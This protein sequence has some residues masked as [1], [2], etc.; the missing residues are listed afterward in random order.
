M[1]GTV[2][3]LI[4][5]LNGAPYGLD[6]E[7][8]DML[9]DL[10]VVLGRSDLTLRKQVEVDPDELIESLK[11]VHSKHPTSQALA[12]ALS[13]K[14]GVEL[15]WSV[16]AEAGGLFDPT[17]KSK[18]FRPRDSIIMV[19]VERGILPD[20]ALL[21]VGSVKVATRRGKASKA[22]V[23]VDTNL[24]PKSL[25]DE[26]RMAW[27]RRVIAADKAFRAAHPPGSY[28]VP[29]WEPSESGMGMIYPDPLSEFL[30]T[31]EFSRDAKRKK[32]GQN[33]IYITP[34]MFAKYTDE[35]EPDSFMWRSP[36]L[37]QKFERYFLSLWCVPNRCNKCGDLLDGLTTEVK[38][39]LRGK[40]FLPETPSAEMP[41]G[42]RPFMGKHM[43]NRCVCLTKR[44]VK[45][46]YAFKEASKKFGSADHPEAVKARTASY[47][48]MFKAVQE[49]TGDPVSSIIASWKLMLRNQK[50]MIASVRR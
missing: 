13:K 31:H 27:M 47:I 37:L 11:R 43:H 44:D 2:T 23:L 5:L 42:Q 24:R 12:T 6:I 3:S 45:I 41:R 32:D 30:E 20:D 21:E 48:E 18:I 26:D 39:I 33:W 50:E 9:E 10:K 49:E 35:E 38:D 36:Q 7:K 46:K 4:A 1:K 34:E 17:E 19:L 14:H 40:L 8:D 28:F 15:S 29:D 22:L 16:V 25:E